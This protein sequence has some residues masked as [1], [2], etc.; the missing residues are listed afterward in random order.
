MMNALSR[1]VSVL[2]AVLLTL[3]F[4]LLYKKESKQVDKGVPPPS[5]K[6]V[7]NGNVVV[8]ERDGRYAAIVFERQSL[9]DSMSYRWYL[10]DEGETVF[11]KSRQNYICGVDHAER[12]VKFSK[13]K[14]EWSICSQGRGWLYHTSYYENDVKMYTGIV[15]TNTELCGLDVAKVEA[16]HNSIP[17]F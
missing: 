16:I 1:K 11:D 8:L 14:V 17:Y 4:S 6:L 2:S 9:N 5:P 12:W 10:L 7:E 15:V 3:C 13:F